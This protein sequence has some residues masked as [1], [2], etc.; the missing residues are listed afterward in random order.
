MKTIVIAWLEDALI[1]D[2]K[3]VAT[4]LGQRPKLIPHQS[5]H[6]VVWKSEATEADFE[7]AVLYAK[8]HHGP[9]GRVYVY[10]A[11]EQSPLERARKSIAEGK[12]SATSF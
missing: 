7:K 12:P 2:G 8:R 6:A 9:V 3:P 10:E 1:P 4:D 5:A 11:S